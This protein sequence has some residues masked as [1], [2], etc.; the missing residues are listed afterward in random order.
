MLH[1]WESLQLAKKS[2]KMELEAD[3]VVVGSGAG[4]AP[5]AYELAGEGHAVILLEEGGYYPTECF[6]FDCKE[7][8]SKLYRN[9][10]LTFSLGM[11]IIICPVGRSIGGTTTI[12]QGTSLRVPPGVLKEWQTGYGL[13]EINAEE[14]SLYYNAVEEFLFVKKADPEVAGKNAAKFVEGAKKLGMDA[15]YLPRN[16]KDCEGYGVCSFGCPSG[17]KQSTNVSYI[18]EAVKRGAEVYA[19][20]KV[21]T[22]LTQNGRATGLEARFIKNDTG[23]KGPELRVNAQVVVLSGGTIGTPLL[24]MKNRLANSSRQVGKHYRM[25]PCSVAVPIYDEQ[26]NPTKGISQSAWVHD[27]LSEGLS[28]ETTVLSPDMLAMSIPSVSDRHAAIMSQFPH[29]GLVGAM[30]KDTSSGRI[31]PRPGGQFAIL[32]QINREDLRRMQLGN[33]LISEIAFAAGAKKVYTYIAGH[34]ELR[35]QK[36][37]ERLRG[38]KIGPM[39]YLALSAWHPMGTCR[40]G[41]DPSWSVVDHTGETWDVKDLFISDAS[42]FPTALGVNPQLTIMAQALRIAGHIDESLSGA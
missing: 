26:I 19:D 27:F 40:M 23:E 20:C 16:A 41:S 35:G 14:M 7:A 39:D 18:P 11:P 21:H 4:G 37:L 12:N 32:Y 33:I 17:A 36:D 1:T 42:T 2:K 28:L 10:G 22:I 31:I 3:V 15:D 13:H 9:S 24:L 8:V 6:R 29:S 38:S 25:H 5:I 30:V 34:T